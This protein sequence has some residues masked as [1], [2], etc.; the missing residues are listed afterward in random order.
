ME[1][2]RTQNNSFPFIINSSWDQPELG[3][4]Y[5]HQCWL[6]LLQEETEYCLFFAGQRPELQVKKVGVQNLNCPLCLTEEDAV[7]ALPQSP[8][9]DLSHCYTNTPLQFAL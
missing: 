9:P 3:G 2:M 7:G 6:L 8:F 5:L 4:L 1:E